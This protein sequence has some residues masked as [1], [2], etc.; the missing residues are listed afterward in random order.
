M[1]I[2]L[3][4]GALGAEVDGVDLGNSSVENF[5]II[6]NVTLSSRSYSGIESVVSTDD[7]TLYFFGARDNLMSIDKLTGF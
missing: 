6:N 5:K 7:D 4:S 1:D 2:K 3:L